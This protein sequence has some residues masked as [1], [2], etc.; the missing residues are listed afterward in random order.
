MMHLSSIP[1]DGS[2]TSDLSY[3]DFLQLSGVRSRREDALP[4]ADERALL[5]R[6]DGGLEHVGLGRQRRHE[7]D[8]TADVVELQMI[9]RT[10]RLLR[11]D[12]HPRGCSRAE[13]DDRCADIVLAVIERDPLECNASLRANGLPENVMHL[14]RALDAT[15]GRRW[16]FADPC[17]A[18]RRVQLLE[19]LKDRVLAIPGGDMGARIFGPSDE[20]AGARAARRLVLGVL[21][22]VLGGGVAEATTITVTG[23]ADE[24]SSSLPNVVCTLREAV[25]AANT[26]AAFGGCPAGDAAGTDVIILQSGSTYTRT[27]GGA[28]DKLHPNRAGYQA[29]ANAI[30]LKWLMPSRSK[31]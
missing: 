12:L 9:I 17:L 14:K 13:M 25:I 26:N 22:L 6:Q 15:D 31:K 4:A 7:G 23:T 20:N 28:G 29:M 5:D 1:G 21:A 3:C 8:E 24:N 30:D 18:P 10:G 11:G 27:I 16:R 19:D 2:S